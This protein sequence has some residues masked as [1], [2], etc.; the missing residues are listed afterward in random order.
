MIVGEKETIEWN[1]GT[2][3]KREEEAREKSGPSKKL[4]KIKKKHFKYAT[5]NELSKKF[6]NTSPAYHQKKS[7]IREC[8]KLIIR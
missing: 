7:K 4:T 8:I 3:E 1:L 6:Q 2:E 5:T